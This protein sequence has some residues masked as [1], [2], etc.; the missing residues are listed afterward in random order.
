MNPREQALKVR[1]H[2]PGRETFL[3]DVL[4][5]LRRDAKSLPYK[6]LYDERGS[7]L[8][9]KICEVPEYYLTRTEIS[10]MRAHLD[11]M[12][13]VLGPRCMI[14]EYGSG[15]GIKTR[16]LLEC[17]DDPVAW[18][19]IDISIDALAASA[20][21]L[22]SEF[23]AI[24]VLPINADYTTPVDLP[25]PRRSPERKVVFFPGSTIGN[26]LPSQAID[27]MK[28]VAAVTGP[29]GGLLIGVDLKK[30]TAIL[31]AAYDDAQGVTARFSTNLL[32]RINREL[33]GDIPVERFAHVACYNPDA[34]RIEIFLE[35]REAITVRIAGEEIS[36]L[37][38]ERI[39]TE[40]SYKYD[41]EEFAALASRAGLS[42]RRIWT[43]PRRLFSVQYLTVDRV[44]LF[45]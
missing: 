16:L 27:F 4:D 14:I 19:P 7:K 40:Y 44:P 20:R 22:N 42:V 29:H 13:S 35:A 5:G 43:D 21:W 34:G 2:A 28:R 38:G 18:V 26:F 25:H 6:Y 10:I 8:F 36:F 1:H 9:E 32:H 30:D 41:P 15:S 23:P 45:T 37:E 24:E 31:E 12:A 33:D 17:L 39:H 11:D 3:A